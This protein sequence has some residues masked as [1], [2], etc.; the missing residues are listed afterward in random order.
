MKTWLALLVGVVALMLIGVVATKACA[1]EGLPPR[2]Y[3]DLLYPEHYHCDSEPPVQIALPHIVLADAQVV[4]TDGSP[5]VA[6]VGDVFTDEIRLVVPAQIEDP[7]IP[8]H[9][10]IHLLVPGLKFNLAGAAP[11]AASVDSGIGFVYL[12]GKWQYDTGKKNADGSEIKLPWLGVTF[13]AQGG[14]NISNLLESGFCAV[15]AGVV[16][17]DGITLALAYDLV[18]ATPEDGLFERNESALKS[19]AP[20][21]FYS[22]PLPGLP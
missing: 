10:E 15:G 2:C 1:Q 7:I 8:D 17:L 21:I 20:E 18:S 6:A 13:F 19:L 9:W 11:V 16:L 3:G 4:G 22:W 12:F 14:V 5:V